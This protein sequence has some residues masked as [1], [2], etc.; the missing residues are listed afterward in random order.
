MRLDDAL[1]FIVLNVIERKN[2]ETETA[3][4]HYGFVY[5]ACLSDRVC[6]RQ[7]TPVFKIK[8]SVHSRELISIRF[9]RRRQMTNR[10]ITNMRKTKF[11]A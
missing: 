8:R 5:L 9:G 2:N 11:L 6:L 4:Y 7:T 10:E 3:L 1:V